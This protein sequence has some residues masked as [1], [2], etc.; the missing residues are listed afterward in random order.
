[1][2][3]SFIL[4]EKA[5]KMSI[6]YYNNKFYKKHDN[7]IYPIAKEWKEQIDEEI[8]NKLVVAIAGVK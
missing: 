8:K 5:I 4:Q 1:M 7:Y 2:A 3:Y 6:E